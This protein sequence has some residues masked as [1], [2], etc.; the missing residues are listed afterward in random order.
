MPRSPLMFFQ[1]LSAV[2]VHL[3]LAAGVTTSADTPPACGLL[4]Y[5]SAPPTIQLTTINV[6]SLNPPLS[7]FLAPLP[8]RLALDGGSSAPSSPTSAA[9]PTIKVYAPGSETTE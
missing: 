2:L 5:N 7:A 8:L 4:C 1:M 3:F 6:S 9:L